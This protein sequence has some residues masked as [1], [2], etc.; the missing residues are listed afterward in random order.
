MSDT[1]RAIESVLHE[2]RRFP[3]P[4]EFAKAAHIS[5][6]A[7]YQ[8]MWDRA[9]N[10]PAGFWGD[11]ATSE[12]DWFEPFE[13]VIDGEMPETKWFS[14]GKINLCHNCI[15]R[16]LLTW[17]K[18]KAAIIWE[19]EPGDTR[20]LTYQELHREVCEV[21][22]RAR[23]AGHRDG[24]SRHP[25]HADDSRTRH[26]HAGVCADR[27]D[28]FHHLRRLQCRR[29]R[30]PQ[31]RR[32]VEAGHHRRRRLAARQGDH[33]EGQASTSRWRRA[34]RCRKWSSSNGPAVT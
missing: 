16:H 27:G 2:D 28:A 24:R 33:P 7:Q 10:D 14:G 5:S 22:E 25:V 19:G 29:D 13:T 15:D 8:E 23:L 6:E 4:A 9:K 17:R 1:S 21:R 32:A 3:P 30:R 34:R 26:R 12:L 20:V 18:N 11:L 31:Q